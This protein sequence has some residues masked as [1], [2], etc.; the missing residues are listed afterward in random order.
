MPT[1]EITERLREAGLR[2]TA[3]RVTVPFRGTHSEEEDTRPPLEE[4]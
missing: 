4:P 3:P 1:R 2:V